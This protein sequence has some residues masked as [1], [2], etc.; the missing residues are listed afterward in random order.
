MRFTEMVIGR[1]MQKNYVYT[2]MFLQ[3]KATVGCGVALTWDS[4]TAQQTE[5]YT[6]LPRFHGKM[7]CANCKSG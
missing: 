6:L 3:A 5:L 2:A 4:M 1:H 7:F